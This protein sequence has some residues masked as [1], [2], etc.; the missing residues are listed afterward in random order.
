MS[1]PR[2]SHKSQALG[3]RVSD[4]GFRISALALSLILLLGIPATIQGEIAGALFS[5]PDTTTAADSIVTFNEI[6]YHPA[7]NDPAQEWVELY[8]QMAVDIE[9]SNWR[10]E[11]GIEFSFPTNPTFATGAEK[12][13]FL[14]PVLT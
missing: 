13:L 1:K 9:I 6:M 3:V 12:P 14:A 2:L 5:T 4:F 10:I 11:G 8:N 7:G